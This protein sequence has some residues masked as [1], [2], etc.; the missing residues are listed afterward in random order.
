MGVSDVCRKVHPFTDTTPLRA[1]P[2]PSP[3]PCCA[4]QDKL[5]ETSSLTHEVNVDFART[6]NKMTFDYSMLWRRMPA[7]QFILAALNEEFVAEP[8]PPPRL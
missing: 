7:L 6:L 8:R 2:H 5:V 4:H 3:W 1:S